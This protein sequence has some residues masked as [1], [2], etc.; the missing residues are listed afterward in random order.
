MCG[1]TRHH[2]NVGCQVVYNLATYVLMRATT[3]SHSI[4]H[5]NQSSIGKT[6]YHVE[7]YM[8]K[9]RTLLYRALSLK[10][11]HVAHNNEDAGSIPA[12]PTYGVKSS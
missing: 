2:K 1:H 3:R 11:K 9:L 7:L 10:V 12:R 5:C 4:W 6:L 8:R